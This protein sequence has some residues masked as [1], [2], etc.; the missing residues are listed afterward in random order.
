MKSKISIL[1]IEDDKYLRFQI[2]ETLKEFGPIQEAADFNEALNHLN[3]QYFDLVLTDLDL[4]KG[5]SGLDLIS[6]IKQKNSECIVLSSDE[7]EKSIEKAYTSGANHY[8]NKT[9]IETNLPIY[10][11]KY[12]FSKSSRFEEFLKEEFI[13][14]DAE[15]IEALK[16]ICE[17]NLKNQSLLIEGPTGS[18]KSLLGKLLHQINH[19]QSA[20]VH[21]NCSEFSENLLESELFGHEKGAFTGADQ[22]KDGKFKL[23]D[24]G[25][26]FLD[27]VA[28]MSMNM[29]QKILKA[30]DEKSFY[31]V[32]ASKP[33]K[34]EFTLIT[35]TCENLHEKIQN[36]TFREDLYYRI[37]GYTLK[38]KPLSQRRNDLPSLIKF[39]Q[40][41][42]LRKFI[43]KEDGLQILQNHE[44]PGNIREL[45]QVIDQ[46]SSQGKG[47]LEAGD[48]QKILPL[49]SSI[50]KEATNSGD[51]LNLGLKKYISE[52]EKKAVEESMIRNNGKITACIKELKISS[53][54]FYRILQEHRLKI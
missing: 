24:G 26:L 10:I 13:T 15:T 19:H 4:G 27:E 37:K 7:D 14:Q 8:L 47:I 41:K 25:T 21:V 54:A 29:Q 18:G 32:G 33:I 44:W 35:A 1:I 5:S 12:L 42:T 20:F 50:Q 31:P 48:V 9:K 40:S 6:V 36:K 53:S 22:K 52:I 46:I 2:K 11:K 38:L 45:R 34:C 30:I 49:K 3:S 16:H 28:T 43:I 23:A 17:V 39:F 51:I